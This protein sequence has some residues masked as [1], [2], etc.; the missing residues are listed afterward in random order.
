MKATAARNLERGHPTCLNNEHI[1]GSQKRDAK[2]CQT[3]KLLSVSLTQPMQTVEYSPSKTG[4]F[5]L[6]KAG[7]CNLG[8]TL[9]Y[10]KLSDK[11]LTPSG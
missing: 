4:H 3:A 5:C 11:T 10:N 2:H 7:H 1:L 9:G 8:I 6:D